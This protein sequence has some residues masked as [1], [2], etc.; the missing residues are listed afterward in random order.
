MPRAV[1]PE[2][3]RPSDVMRLYPKSSGLGFG[4]RVVVVEREVLSGSVRVIYRGLTGGKSDRRISDSMEGITFLNRKIIHP[5]EGVWEGE[6]IPGSRGRVVEYNNRRYD[7]PRT[8]GEAKVPTKPKGKPAARGA[9]KSKAAAERAPRAS[10]RELDT[11]SAK[12]VKLRDSQ[13]KD[14]G[15]ICDTLDITPSRARQLYNRGGGE[16][17]P[18][19]AAAPKAKP[20]AKG[21]A[22]AG[23]AASRRRGK[24]NPS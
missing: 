15:T 12:V 17:T 8:E 16:P 6:L 11:L 14:W 2:S 4:K 9:A 3:L 13:N 18:R 20:G 21:K 23:G 19:A 5:I 22:A 1:R 10:E 7:P 24:R